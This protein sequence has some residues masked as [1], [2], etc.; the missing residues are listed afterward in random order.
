MGSES[1]CFVKRRF[2]LHDAR[3]AERDD[4]RFLSF[5]FFFD[6]LSFF[7]PSL[8]S[9]LGFCLSLSPSDCGRLR[10]WSAAGEKC[11]GSGSGINAYP[12]VD[13]AARFR[14]G[15]FFTPGLPSN[16][17]SRSSDSGSPRKPTAGS[18]A[19]FTDGSSTARLS[20]SSSP[21]RGLFLPTA[22]AS[23]AAP[24]GRSPSARQMWR[25]ARRASER[26]LDELT[27]RRVFARNRSFTRSRTLGARQTSLAHGLTPAR[28][29]DR[30]PGARI[31]RP[32]VCRASSPRSRS[33]A[34]KRGSPKF[35]SS[36]ARFFGGVRVPSK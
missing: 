10:G 17:A 29:S 1:V 34:K 21:S 15:R 6:F 30:S 32:R 20:A 7:E 14:A 33:D 18:T 25:S 5:F 36:S 24:P 12:P 9:L 3:V 35:A 8:L 4:E 16:A 19:G 26:A 13:G 23:S 31:E 11:S 27:P 22:D 28:P 2:S